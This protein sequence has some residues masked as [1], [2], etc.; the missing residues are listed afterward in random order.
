M[1]IWTADAVVNAVKQG[2]PNL[3][4]VVSNYFH[5][6]IKRL[7]QYE[8]S[9]HS[10]TNAEDLNQKVLDGISALET[11]RKEILSI[12][13]LFALSE[14]PCLKT[15]LP[16]FFNELIDY[17]ES[18]NINLYSGTTIDVLRNDHYR[19]FNQFLFI[20]VASTL[21]ENRCFETLHLIIKDK[22]KIFNSSYN[23]V[24]NVNFIHYRAYNYTLN[25]LLNSGPSKRISMT[26]DYISRFSGPETFEK[27]IRA[28]ILL[29]YL[30]LWNHTDDFLDSLWF[31]ELSVYNRNLSI[32]PYMVSR[33]Y[34]EKA[35]ILFGITTI[36]AYKQLIAKTSD[37]LE[38]NGL[39]HVP[40]LSEGLMLDTVAT[41]D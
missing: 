10:I 3:E 30:S 16:R 40:M 31:P 21:L 19:F 15:N 12:V 20:S 17:Y 25:Q 27:L 29:Y 1:D 9:L 38:R 33:S 39:F 34:F 37:K 8:I 23:I 24:R 14:H 13:E 22:Y 5:T 36:D 28:D 35:K 7:G 26:A 11:L 32:L 6:V 41:E 2:N 4:V 18:H